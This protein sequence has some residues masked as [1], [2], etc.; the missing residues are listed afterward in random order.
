M[1]YGSR[2]FRPFQLG[3]CLRVTFT[4]Y[5]GRGGGWPNR[6]RPC[7]IAPPSSVI[8]CH[9][10]NGKHLDADPAVRLIVA[11]ACSMYP[12]IFFH[13]YLSLLDNTYHCKCL[14]LGSAREMP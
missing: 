3:R 11:S 4:E 5:G 7:C 14:G 8:E 12:C 1:Q 6:L 9:Q 10:G 13:P 2:S